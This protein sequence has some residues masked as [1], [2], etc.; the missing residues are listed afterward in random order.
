MSDNPQE[1]LN[2]ILDEIA[3]AK[4]A[5]RNGVFKIREKLTDQVGIYVRD[6][7]AANTPY[8]IDMRKCPQCAFEWDIIIIF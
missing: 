2:Y 7:L 8:R 4:A 5:G 6:Y 1:Y 3:A